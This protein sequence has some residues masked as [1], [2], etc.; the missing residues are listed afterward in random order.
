MNQ[1]RFLGWV[2]RAEIHHS[3]HPALFDG[4]RYAQLQNWLDASGNICLIFLIIGSC[5]VE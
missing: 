3:K 4:V 1:G 5:H 2:E